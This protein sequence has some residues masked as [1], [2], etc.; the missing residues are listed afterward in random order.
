LQLEPDERAGGILVVHQDR[1]AQRVLGR[2]LAATLRPVEVVELA[3]ARERAGA[4]TIVVVDIAQARGLVRAPG[5]RWIA[6]PGEETPASPEDVGALLDAGWSHVLASPL[7]LAGDE[8]AAT[9]QKLLRRSIFGLEKY[10]GWSAVIRAATLDDALDRPGAVAALVA[11]VG[12]AGLSERVV[13]LASV[14]ADEL[15][16]N[17][18]YDA[19]I[20]ASGHR[21]HQGAPRDVARAL[22][23][24]DAVT[25]RWACDARVLALEVADAWGSLDPATPGPLISRAT[26]RSPRAETE[27]GMGLALAYACCHQLVVGVAPRRRTELI[28]LI[29]VRHRPAE[30]G[31]APSFH[32]FVEEV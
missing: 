9:A 5:P 15:L 22:A 11:G 6:V 12:D 32:L 21:P 19:S 23:G 8:L 4:D 30:V 10:V 1:K 16:A 13:S 2:I 29:D 3:A 17:A 14:I 7:G 28:A 27:G 26:R 24:R 20:D 31:R 25:L 18:I